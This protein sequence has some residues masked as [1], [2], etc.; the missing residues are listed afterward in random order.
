[1][2]Q[3]VAFGP[4]GDPADGRVPLA[5]AVVSVGDARQGV[6][7]TTDAQGRYVF[8]DL[9][10]GCG[11]CELT[12][13]LPGSATAIL[14]TSVALGGNPSVTVSDLV[15]GS[16]RDQL[17][18]TGRILPPAVEP[19]DPQPP[20]PLTVGVRVYRGNPDNPRNLIV[21]SATV[22]PGPGG[23]GAYQLLLGR[24]GALL[25]GQYRV[26]LF[27]NGDNVAQV[28]IQI[29]HPSGTFAPV[30]VT[31]ADLVGL[32]PPPSAGRA[33]RGTVTQVVAFGPGW[34]PGRRPGAPRRGGRQ[35][36]GRPPGRPGPR[37][38]PRAATSSPT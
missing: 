7:T 35:R 12:V 32:N 30:V 20:A 13:T 27:E 34:R 24:A 23:F 26:F 4:G 1:M 11:T 22:F 3:V 9:T 31:A 10:L 37:P 38:T 18:V 28:G 15:V 8:T 25:P 19:G 14:Q 6:R 2:T 5:G 33:L 36:R 16:A 17:Y 21:D 29:P